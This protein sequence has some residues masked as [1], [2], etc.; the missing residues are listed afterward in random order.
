MVYFRMF[1]NKA[2]DLDSMRKDALATSACHAFYLENTPE[3]HVRGGDSAGTRALKPCIRE[4]T[5]DSH[6]PRNKRKTSETFFIF[7][8][9]LGCQG[10]CRNLSNYAGE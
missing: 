2:V 6:H 3:L 5:P 10:E 8:V 1:L 7:V 9:K 4:P